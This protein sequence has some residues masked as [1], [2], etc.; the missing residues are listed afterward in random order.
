MGET[1]K[2]LAQ[3]AFAWMFNVSTSVVIVFV[4]KILMGK[5]GY[6]FNFGAPCP[7]ELPSLPGFDQTAG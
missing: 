7:L 2:K 3:D 4:N 5:A 6:M 1:D